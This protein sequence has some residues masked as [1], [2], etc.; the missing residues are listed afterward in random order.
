MRGRLADGTWRQNFD[1]TEWGGPYT[2]ASAWHYSWSVLH[3]IP[4]LIELMGGD[5]AFTERLDAMLSAEPKFQEGSYGRTIHE[6]AEMV[7]CEMGQYAHG[8]QPVHHVL[9]LYNFAGVPWKGAP[10]IRKAVDTLYGPGPA[11]YCG[12]EDNGQM[13]A[14][15]IFSTLGFY[16]VC[17]G[18]PAYVLGSPRFEK[19]TLHLPDGKQ[20]E[21]EAHGNSSENIY[22]QAASLNGKTLSQSWIAHSDIVSGGKLVLEM[23]PQPNL[24]WGGARRIARF[25]CTERRP[26]TPSYCRS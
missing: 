16:P 6:M 23:G 14:W 3:D 19:A 21:V 17:P 10:A 12:D 18:E 1:A 7:A 22:V 25:A 15:Y 24:F 20:F 13:S 4:G 5:R 11:G 2:E 9:Y 26:V 8:N